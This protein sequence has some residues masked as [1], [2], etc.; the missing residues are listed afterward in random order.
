MLCLSLKGIYNNTTIK[1]MSSSTALIHKKLF[2]DNYMVPDGSVIFVRSYIVS[3]CNRLFKLTMM[4][5]NISISVRRAKMEFEKA[6]RLIDFHE[7]VILNLGT[8]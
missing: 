4:P 6:F 1:I 5:I 3:C 8:Q 7:F 2:T